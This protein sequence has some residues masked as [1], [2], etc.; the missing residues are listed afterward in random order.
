[1]LAGDIAR[2]AAAIGWASRFDVPVLYVPGNHE[3]YG[4]SLAGTVGELKRLSAGSQIHVLDNEALIF[5]GV[6]FLGTTLW[7]D[8]DLFA[9]EDRRRAAMREATR[10]MRDFERIESFTPDTSAALFRR[11]AAWL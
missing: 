3:F 4:G 11:N 8:F 10:F 9:D 1:M 7:S 5:G 6:R 2:P